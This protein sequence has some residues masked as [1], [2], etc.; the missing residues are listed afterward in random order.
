MEIAGKLTC[1]R[2]EIASGLWGNVLGASEDG[3]SVYFVASSALAGAATPANCYEG[4]TCNLYMEQLKGGER[5]IH[6]IGALASGFGT[7]GDSLDWAE[8]ISDQTARVSRDGRFLAFMSSRSLTGYD[9]HDVISGQA[10][11]EAYLYDAAQQRLMCAS[12][13]PTGA[14]PQGVFYSGSTAPLM[15]PIHSWSERWVAATLPPWRSKA[16]QVAI[17]QPRYLSDSGR[18]FFNSSDA[19]LPQDTNGL[20]DVYEYEPDGVG[21]CAEG[22]G[23]VDLISS[24]ASGE[25]AGFLDASATGD[26][27]FFITSAR[28]TQ[29][30][31]DTAFDLY[32][33]HVCTA[34]VPC[35][36]QAS[37][38]PPCGSGDACKA[39]PTPQPTS[40]G[41]PASATFSGHGNTVATAPA[42]VQRRSAPTRTQ[43]LSRA[44]ELCRRRHAHH[45]RKLA[46]CERRARGLYGKA[47]HGGHN[48][49]GH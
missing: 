26:D 24:G 8:T 2:R 23:C 47:A 21:S 34:S 45:R 27:A 48:G 29:G 40:F 9:N 10:D 11:E 39:P 44:L 35:T 22:E 17:Y 31:E 43:K 7:E 1:D 32:D 25:E 30:D 38:P 20:S 12:C 37:T 28:L 3:S 18:L 46:A 16:I 14:R 36:Q 33:A 13:N 42:S 49:R 41:A 15:D 4:P 19:L 6:F 5:S